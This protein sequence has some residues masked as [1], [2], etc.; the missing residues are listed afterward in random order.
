MM[1][2]VALQLCLPW[3]F[4]LTPFV[5]WCTFSYLAMKTRGDR[6]FAHE[7]A[8][9][10]EAHSAHA[11]I[12]CMQVGQRTFLSCLSYPSVSIS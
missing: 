6:V 2:F 8:V 3:Q 9:G 12:C 1:T 10:G 5:Q 7:F 4:G 11:M